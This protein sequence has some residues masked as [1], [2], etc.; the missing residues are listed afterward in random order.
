[1]AGR[2][3]Y[4]VVSNQPQ[5]QHHRE[6]SAT[7]TAR[8]PA[9]FPVLRR[10]QCFLHRYALETS[11]RKMSQTPS[12]LKFHLEKEA[13]HSAIWSHPAN[14]NVQQP[15]PT[16]PNLPPNVP[17]QV[18]SPASPSPHYPPPHLVSPKNPSNTTPSA[19]SLRSSSSTKPA[20]QSPC[21]FT[22]PS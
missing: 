17:K 9:P 14:S 18:K 2:A 10:A 20:A 3:I 11:R 21:L 12:H 6:L 16:S 7:A 13:K 22:T 1:M 5:P 19:F 4:L 8:A 15:H